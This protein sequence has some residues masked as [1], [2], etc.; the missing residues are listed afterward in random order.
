MMNN[1]KFYKEVGIPVAKKG[2]PASVGSWPLM[3]VKNS[4]ATGA[5]FG[6][7]MEAVS[8]VT[9]VMDGK[10]DVVDAAVDIAGAGVKGGVI[11]A[12]SAVAGNAAA[13]AWLQ[14]RLVLLLW[15]L[16]LSL[17]LR[18]PVLWLGPSVIS[19]MRFLT[20]RL[21][22]DLGLCRCRP[23]KADFKMDC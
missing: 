20:S 19:S 16:R 15:R 3:A 21:P 4:G 22:Y 7:G 1:Q 13:G 17:A 8:S 10:K 9:D 18:R 23:N 11:G 2:Y 14:R 5:L 12:V 6:A